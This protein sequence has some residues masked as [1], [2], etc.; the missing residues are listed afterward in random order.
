MRT[1]QIYRSDVAAVIKERL[2]MQ[3]VAEHYG[4]HPNRSGFIQCPFHNGDRTASL[5]IY[6][7][8]GGFHCFGCN[9]HGS[10][11]DF[12]MQLYGIDFA[13][14]VIRISSD[15][16]LDLTV[17]RAPSHIEAKIIT[18]R[19]QKEREQQEA[20]EEYNR[21]TQEYRRLW[22]AKREFAPETFLSGIYIHPLYAEALQRLPYL[23]YWLD[24]RG[25]EIYKK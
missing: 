8:S 5:K 4:F 25:G 7:G 11:I 3:Q 22:E 17:R 10:V 23:E 12:V 15:F 24:A 16:G 1:K 18:E 20:E 6:P 2:T 13:Q 21:M 9:A 14:A 19:K